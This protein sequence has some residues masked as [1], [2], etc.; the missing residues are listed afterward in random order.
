[1]TSLDIKRSLIYNT[2][3]TS[4]KC[5]AFAAAFGRDTAGGRVATS[6]KRD[7]GTGP[8]GKTYN[9]YIYIFIY[10]NDIGK[11]IHL[12]KFGHQD[13]LPLAHGTEKF[14]HLGRLLMFLCPTNPHLGDVAVTSS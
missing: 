8:V 5:P 4:P 7:H 11:R 9:I 3:N 1:M 2:S 13:S 6:S 14:G 10:I 12:E